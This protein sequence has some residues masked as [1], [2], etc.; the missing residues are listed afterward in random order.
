MKCSGYADGK[1][2]CMRYADSIS[3]DGLAGITVA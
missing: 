1:K 2:D 3:A